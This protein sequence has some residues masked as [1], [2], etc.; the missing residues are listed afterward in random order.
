MKFETKIFEEPQLEFG[1]KHHHPDPRLGLSEAGPLQIPLGDVV[2][3]AVIGSSKTVEDTKEFFEEAVAGFEGKGEKHPNL[4][5]DFPGLGNQN[6]YRCKFEISDGATIA[7]SQS[8][9]DK[10]RKEP[11]HYKAVEMAVDEIVQQLQ[12]LDET[13][14]RPD[15]AI[16]A[17]PVELIERVWN[18]KVDSK[19]TTEK[20]D[21]GGSDAPDF[22]GMLK[23]KAMDLSFP[24]QIAWEDVFDE[25]AKIPL[26]VKESRARKIQDQADRTWNLLTT[27][28]YKG[29]GRIPW[30][31]MPQDGEFTACYIGISFYR[32]VGGQQ[33]F[34]SAAQ[35]FDER[36]RGF[37][38]KGKRA[39]T[40]SRGRHPY[41]TQEDAHELVANALTAYKNHHKHY[42]ARVIV[43]KTSKFR[44]EEAEG[45]FEA[46][47]EAGLEFRD[48]VWVQESYSVKVL[49]DGNY[50]VMRGTFV[51]LDG[52]G[53][54]YT[55]G[56]IPYYGTYPGMYDPRPLL[57]CP[58][59]GS[60][61]TVA[62]IAS[63]VLALTKVN[64]NSTQMNQKLPIPIRAARAVGEVL[65]YTTDQKVSSD[66]ARYI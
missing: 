44:E 3:I 57:L 59:E 23:A 34:T 48:L 16:V 19:A 41:M 25:S 6:P 53:L 61:S 60:D 47:N 55:N 17:L 63:E 46:I 4:H 14:H 32:E 50:P 20:D 43:L 66:Y 56:S 29:T 62:Q 65:K 39:Q 28:Y 30:R 15:V 8:K 52:K 37:I 42:P 45:I 13:S 18:A 40:E 21:S 49:R 36:G 22:R 24:I 64:W 58:Y 2:K 54:L 33:L 9:I 1:D 5:P 31:K 26:K 11:H 35:M 51:D 12:T 27:I 10:I 7:I 38:L